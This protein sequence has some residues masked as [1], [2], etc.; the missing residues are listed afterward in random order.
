MTD[1]FRTPRDVEDGNWYSDARAAVR[2]ASIGSKNDFNE[3][4]VAERT[5]IINLSATYP[6]SQTRDIWQNVNDMPSEE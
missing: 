2:D 4:T 5:N 6:L 1:T 3:F